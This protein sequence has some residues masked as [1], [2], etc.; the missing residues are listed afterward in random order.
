MNRR[1]P[2]FPSLCALIMAMTVAHC[3][4]QSRM[5]YPNAITD[6]LVHAKTPMAPPPVNTVFTDRDF[7]SPMVRVSDETTNPGVSGGYLRTEGSGQRVAWSSDTKKFYIVAEGGQ[8]LVFG[9]DPNTMTILTL[10]GGSPGHGLVL[11]LQSG[12][13]FSWVDP[14]LIYGPTH[15]RPLTISSYRFSTGK[16][17]TVLDT[18][19]CGTVPALRPTAKS[20]YDTSLSAHDARI[21]VSEGG[22]QFGQHMFMIVYDTQLGCRWYNTQTGQIGGQWGPAGNVSLPGFLIGHAKLSKDGK[23]VEFNGTGNGRVFWQ[24]DTLTVTACPLHSQLLCSGYGATGTSHFID[25]LGTIDEMNTGIRPLANISQITQLVLPLSP[26][27]YFGLQRHF[28]WV[29]VDALDTAPVCGSTY[30]YKEDYSIMTRPFED[31]VECIETDL[32]ASTVWR[33]AHTR[34]SVELGYFASQPVGT[35]SQDGRFYMFTS[36]WDGQVGIESNGLPR[37]DVWIVKLD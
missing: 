35:V 31:E 3:A 18:T 14:D 20:D 13:S 4:A 32:L 21:A 11:P 30:L 19:T 2:Q 1:L 27:Y 29:N 15:K 37:S 33:F 17:S 34:A 5:P 12:A 6:R 7:G 25:S 26:P 8:A 10:P 23:Y 24:V 36:N 9:F 22:Q 28:S 16:V